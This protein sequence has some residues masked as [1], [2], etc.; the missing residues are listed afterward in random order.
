MGQARTVDHEGKK[1]PGEELEFETVKENWNVYRAED[2]TEIKMKSVVS[3][4]IRLEAY[5]SDGEPI[6]VIKSTNLVASNVPEILKHKPDEKET[7][8]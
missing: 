2:G 8:H 5:K 7:A 6:Y 3:N 1:V 4:I